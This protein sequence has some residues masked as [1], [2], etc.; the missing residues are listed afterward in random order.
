MI[1]RRMKTNTLYAQIEDSLRK[2][3]LAG[4]YPEDAALP[5][6]IQLSLDYTASRKTVRKALENLRAQ[7]FIRKARGSGNFV[8]PAAERER[9]E[10]VTGKLHL[11]LP[12]GRVSAGFVREIV[13]GVHKFAAG[14]GLEIT[15]GSHGDSETALLDAYRNFRCDALIWCACPHPLPPTVAALAAQRVPQVIVDGEAQGAGAVV[16]DSLPAWRSLCNMLRA[17]GHRELA[18][19]ERPGELSWAL[20]RQRALR[21]AASEYD[22]NATIFTADFSASGELLEFVETH[23]EITAYVSISPWRDALRQ[24]FERCGKAVPQDVSWAEFTP[25]GIAPESPMTRIYI[26]TQGMGYEAARLVTGNDF[27]S[28]PT[29]F[30]AIACFTVAGTSTGAAPGIRS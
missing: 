20:A 16:Y 4:K 24:V 7:N 13:A 15:F 30:S 10:R 25:D 29:P 23:P 27:S 1:A 8:I 6:E 5:G 22:M 3:I 18:F 11:L 2:N 28:N 9:M 19:I 17:A 14:R 21:Q 26:P 12:D